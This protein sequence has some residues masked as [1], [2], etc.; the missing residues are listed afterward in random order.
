MNDELE[1]ER[2]GI[3]VTFALHARR[4]RSELNEWAD[5]LADGD[6]ELREDLQTIENWLWA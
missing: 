6:P 3:C 4:I 1:Q 5:N 2:A